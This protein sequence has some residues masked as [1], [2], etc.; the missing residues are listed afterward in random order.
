VIM[1][2]A[3]S[4]SVSENPAFPLKMGRIVAR[5][6]TSAR[7]ATRVPLDGGRQVPTLPQQVTD[8]R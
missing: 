5:L 3:T 4:S 2:T 8:M 1:V 6:A 7:M